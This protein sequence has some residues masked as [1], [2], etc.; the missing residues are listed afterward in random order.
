MENMIGM[1]PDD[2]PGQGLSLTASFSHFSTVALALVMA[3]YI[4]RP[5]LRVSGLSAM[6]AHFVALSMPLLGLLIA[7]AIQLLWVEKHKFKVGRLRERLRLG[8]FEY[9]HF[10]AA[11][12]LYAAGYLSYRVLSGV[13]VFLLQR[14]YLSIPFAASPMDNPL[15]P[16][17]D[18]MLGLAAGGPL[19][20]DYGLLWLYAGALALN[21]FAEELYWRGVILPRQE[22]S[23]GKAAWFW[24]GL[25]WTLS[26]AYKY[27]DLLNLLPFCLMSAFVASRMKSSWP[28]LL[29]HTGLNLGGFAFIAGKILGA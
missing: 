14:G 27:W 25:L 19:H 8:T 20:G 9:R 13:S 5:A 1:E 10:L 24:H 21:I 11:S 17:N 26:H 2:R 3:Y 18:A 12:G 29:A 6:R 22:M 16:R 23:L 7:A 28:S 15:I 4:L